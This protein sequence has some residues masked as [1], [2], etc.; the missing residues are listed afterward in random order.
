MFMH[1]HT[2]ASNSDWFQMLEHG[3]HIRAWGLQ[4]G[5]RDPSFASP[6]PHHH[7][8]LEVQRRKESS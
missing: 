2:P 3:K 8:Y 6:E 7:L 4:L 5:V 1:T